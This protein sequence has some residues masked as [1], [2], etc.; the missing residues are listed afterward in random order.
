MAP[1]RSASKR[2]VSATSAGCFYDSLNV[3][4]IEPSEGP[5]KPGADPTDA[6]YVDT[7]YAAETCESGALGAFG[8]A[9][10]TEFWEGDQPGFAVSATA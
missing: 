4:L 3:A 9:K 7:T 6:V 10:C 1:I 8:P 5:A 2:L